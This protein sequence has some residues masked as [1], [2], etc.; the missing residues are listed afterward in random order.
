MLY[1]SDSLGIAVDRLG[2]LGLDIHDEIKV[3]IC[4]CDTP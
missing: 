3:D 2:A 1:K 4:I